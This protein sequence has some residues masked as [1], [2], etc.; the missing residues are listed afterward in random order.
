MR[1]LVFIL[2]VC[3]AVL[4][5]S[6]EGGVAFAQPAGNSVPQLRDPSLPA[7]FYDGKV[8]LSYSFFG[9][10]ASGAASLKS[11]F[12]SGEW[13]ALAKSVLAQG[14]VWDVYYIYLGRSAH[15]LGFPTAAKEYYQK[16]LQSSSDGCR[17]SL[18]TDVCQGIEVKSVAERYLGGNILPPEENRFDTRFYAT[19]TSVRDDE[20]E[21]II[22]I[23][24]AKVVDAKINFADLRV[25]FDRTGG[26]LS[27]QLLIR[28]EYPRVGPRV[29]QTAV[30][31]SRSGPVQLALKQIQYDVDCSR[32]SRPGDRECWH[33]ETVTVDLPEE[34]FRELARSY[35]PNVR[36][37]WR[38]R[39]RSRSDEDLT[40]AVPYAA[41]A[42]VVPVVDASVAK[43]RDRK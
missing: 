26:A 18:V 12:D 31:A 5:L 28:T 11:L 24:T 4:G 20:L 14:A 34:L 30:G 32:A 9:K 29:Y 25:F 17:L 13:V 41:F 3:S 15:E 2:V 1:A 8:K 33:Y 16:A 7:E 37:E 23:T 36:A 27:Y 19:R 10:G 21:T 43:V 35:D 42:A 39:I 6:I 38:I 40:L 22:R